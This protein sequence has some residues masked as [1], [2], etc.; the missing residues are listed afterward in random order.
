MLYR[1]SSDAQ[2]VDVAALLGELCG[3]LQAAHAK[4]P[5]EIVAESDPL[6]L[7]AGRATSL[8][9]VAGE[10]AINALKHAFPENRIGRIVVRCRRLDARRCRLEVADDGVGRAVQ[11]RKGSLGMKL[12][13]A[14][15]RTLGGELQMSDEDGVR[16]AVDFEA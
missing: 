11:P 3:A 5:V 14:L 10:A 16:V 4:R 9:L 7:D 8:A 13:R 12:M 6:T 1:H 2:T 15:A